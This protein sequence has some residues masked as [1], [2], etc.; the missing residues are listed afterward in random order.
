MANEPR[1]LIA[2]LEEHQRF[3]NGGQN[4]LI[5]LLIFQFVMLWAFFIATRSAVQEASV[6]TLW[7]A[8]KHPAR[9]RRDRRSPTRHGRLLECYL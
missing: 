1:R 2:T 3:S 7:I 5:L 8:G 4:A 6:G 9:E